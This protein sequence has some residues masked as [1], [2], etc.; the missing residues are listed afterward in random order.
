MSLFFGDLLS[1][2]AE[3]VEQ[4]S[5][6]RDSASGYILFVELQASWTNEQFAENLCPQMQLGPEQISIYSSVYRCIARLDTGE[7]AAVDWDGLYPVL[8]STLTYFE[9][10]RS[11]LGLGSTIPTFPRFIRSLRLDSGFTGP[12][13][14]QLFQSGPTQVSS[15]HIVLND[16]NL[17]GSIPDSLLANL[18]VSKISSLALYINNNPLSGPFP[19]GLLTELF[20]TG[21]TCAIGS[22][23]HPQYWLL[24]DRCCCLTLLPRRSSRS[25]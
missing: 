8:S 21:L 5:F 18:N 7:L 25:S 15:A 6:G 2:R 11:Q 17:N 20:A 9:I 19:S 1:F 16:N 4:I 23:H 3:N 13:P 12:L 24:L 14:A 22:V 10:A